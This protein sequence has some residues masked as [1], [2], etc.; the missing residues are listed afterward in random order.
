MSSNR[1]TFLLDQYMGRIVAVCL[2]AALS[3]Y[4]QTAAIPATR[5]Y[6]VFLRPDPLR[7]PLVK[8]DSERIQSAHMA[9]I[10]SMARDGILLS[11]GPFEDTPTTISGMLVFHVDSLES[12]QRIAARDP[13]VLGHRNNVE[14]HAWQGPPGIGAEYFRLHKLDPKT[15]ENMQPHPLCLLYRGPAWGQ[16]AGDRDS[17]LMAHAHYMDG[18]REQGKLGAAGEIEPPD[19]LLYLTIFKPIAPADTNATAQSLM[20]EDPAVKAGVLRVEY[21]RWWSSDHV[22]PW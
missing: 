6:V 21:H 8:A 17:L 11:A 10:Q 13:T 7:K 9:N 19:D 14:V 5:Y 15:P 2:M 18:L 20:Q 3:S 12:A 4:A 1:Y 22:L 16:H